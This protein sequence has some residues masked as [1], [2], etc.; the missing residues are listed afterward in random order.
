MIFMTVISRTQLRFLEKKFNPLQNNIMPN[1]FS[2]N[3]WFNIK[4]KFLVVATVEEI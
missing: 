3:K 4:L 1:K 2:N